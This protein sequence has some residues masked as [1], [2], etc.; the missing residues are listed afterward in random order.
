MALN[1]SLMSESLE[2]SLALEWNILQSF[3]LILSE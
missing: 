2:I 1:P 3:F